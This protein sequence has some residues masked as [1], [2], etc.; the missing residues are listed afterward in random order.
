LNNPNRKRKCPFPNQE[1][2]SSKRVQPPEILIAADAP[3]PGQGGSPSKDI[4]ESLQNQAQAQAQ[5]Q[6][7]YMKSSNAHA[8]FADFRKTL[9]S[10]ER[11]S[12]NLVPEES[13]GK[14]SANPKPPAREPDKR[15]QPARGQ[16]KLN[17]SIQNTDPKNRASSGFI[18]QD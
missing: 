15:V 13:K 9:Q 5:A 18:H 1:E 7:Q 10:K 8:S 6:A 4:Q 12:P 17:L 14:H 11:T 2:S 3:Q 16:S